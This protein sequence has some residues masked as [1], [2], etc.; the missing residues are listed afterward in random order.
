MESEEESYKEI[1]ELMLTHMDGYTAKSERFQIAS[2]LRQESLED[3]FGIN[4]KSVKND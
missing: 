2:L 3:G 4:R 1:C